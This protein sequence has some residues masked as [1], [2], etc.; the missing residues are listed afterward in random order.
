[1]YSKRIQPFGTVI[2]SK[3]KFVNNL[4]TNFLGYFL[5]EKKKIIEGFCNNS[6]HFADTGFL[7]RIWKLPTRN[8]NSEASSNLGFYAGI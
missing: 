7:C 4:K 5:V 8:P 1:M 6:L 3:P 2:F